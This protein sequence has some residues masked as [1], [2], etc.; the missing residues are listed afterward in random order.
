M[1]DIQLYKIHLNF[2]QI[3]FGGE[4]LHAFILQALKVIWKC[5]KRCFFFS[6]KGIYYFVHIN[7]RN[8][9]TESLRNNSLKNLEVY[10]SLKLK[11]AQ[12]ESVQV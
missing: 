11:E 7:F 10:F 1:W 6:V 4:E 9:L 5:F 2:I 3:Y 8:K 12:R